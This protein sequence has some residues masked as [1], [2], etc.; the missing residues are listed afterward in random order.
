M[1]IS[2]LG[3]EMQ[4]SVAQASLH[5]HEAM[6]VPTHDVATCSFH[7]ITSLGSVSTGLS[8]ML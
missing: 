8:G 7:G 5:T 6:L 2:H 1:V 3:V 4:H